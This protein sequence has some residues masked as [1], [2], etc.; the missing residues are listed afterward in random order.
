MEIEK[1]NVMNNNLI[2]VAR[3]LGQ[4]NNFLEL[5]RSS[6]ANLKSVVNSNRTVIM[7]NT[8]VATVR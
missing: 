3:C 6:S 2:G 1:K 4:N 7:T 8:E 5:I